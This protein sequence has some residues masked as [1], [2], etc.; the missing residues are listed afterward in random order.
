MSAN[1]QVAAGKE[2]GQG[3]LDALGSIVGIAGQA[4]GGGAFGG[5]GG[6]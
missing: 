5:Y 1:N 4:F 2:A 3:M 6:F